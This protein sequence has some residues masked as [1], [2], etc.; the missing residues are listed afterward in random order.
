MLSAILT[1][2]C[3]PAFDTRTDETFELH[4]GGWARS[5]GEG[6]LHQ[7]CVGV[8]DEPVGARL[9]VTVHFVVPTKA[10]VVVLVRPGP[11]RWKL[12]S[13]V[14]SRTSIVYLPA[15]SCSTFA[16]LASFKSIV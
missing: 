7:R 4:L 13:F 15:W 2:T 8:T 3:R 1:T 11:V 14:W 9:Q 16:P 5:D 6:A 12:C 10:T